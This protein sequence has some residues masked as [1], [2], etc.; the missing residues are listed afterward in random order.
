MKIIIL[1]QTFP[2]N[3][4]D[5][6]AHFMYDFAKGLKNRN[7]KI[8]VLIPFHPKLQIN[9]FKNI[10]IVPFRY[11]WPP[12][13]HRLGYGQTLENDQKIKWSVY[14][15]VPF[16]FIFATTSL[17]KEISRNKIDIISAHWILPSGF[18]AAIVS[19]LT[20]VPIV[21]T[22]PG[23]D[24]YIAR[25]NWILKLMSKFALSTAHT[26]VS[27]SPQFLNDLSVKGEVISYPVPRNKGKRTE[28]TKLKIAAAGRAVE[29]KGL[30]IIKKVYPQI[31]IIQGLP[32]QKFRQKLL[33]V[34]I[35]IAYSI[36]D[37]KGNLDDASVTVLEAMAAG[38]AVITTDLPGYRQIIKNGENG[39]LIKSLSELKE[40]IGM[41]KKSE[42]LRK[43]L[44]KNARLTIRK[45]LTPKLIAKKYISLLKLSQY[46]PAQT[47]LL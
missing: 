20:S 12:Q 35:F 2:F 34:D 15:L 46:E 21:I 17:Y 41:L 40:A 26:I 13:L 27:D 24:A 19:K 5:H 38:C 8:T 42:S 23:S 16:F 43:R 39:L 25:Q 10:R 22:I 31:E 28:N 45:H 32:I 37:S 4:K 14:P 7:N 6:T 3:P 18:I 47:P 1:S 29:K 44:G 11:I 9:S 33:D 36:R 30:D